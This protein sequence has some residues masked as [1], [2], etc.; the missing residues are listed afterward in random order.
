[1]AKI[2]SKGDFFSWLPFCIQVCKCRDGLLQKA[3]LALFRV[4]KKNSDMQNLSAT[5][6]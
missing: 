1:M 3:S 4:R 6:L 2:L 5:G